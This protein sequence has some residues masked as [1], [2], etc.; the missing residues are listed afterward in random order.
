MEPTTGI[1]EAVVAE[2]RDLIKGR[3][4][5]ISSLARVSGVKRGTL[6][7]YVTRMRSPM[8][9]DV[10]EQVAN[11]FGLTLDELARMAEDRRERDRKGDSPIQGTGS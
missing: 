10:V 3:G 7:N 5:T 2:V 6:V 4:M 11:A 1:N 9:I 8:P